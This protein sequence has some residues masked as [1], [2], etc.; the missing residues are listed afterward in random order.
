MTTYRRNDRRDE[1]RTDVRPRRTLRGRFKRAWIREKAIFRSNPI[2]AVVSTIVVITLAVMARHYFPQA[3][4]IGS[5]T[6][7]VIFLIAHWCSN[8]GAE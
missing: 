5:I 2:S 6:G 4:A 1:P 7:I 8:R 3:Y